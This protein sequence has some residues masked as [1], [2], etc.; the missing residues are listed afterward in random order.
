VVRFLH[1]GPRGGGGFGDFEAGSALVDSAL[2]L[3]G[4]AIKASIRSD[5]L[6]PASVTARSTE[7]G[8]LRRCYTPPKR[9]HDSAR[10][11][12]YSVKE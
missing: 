4:S 5:G 3:V 2:V 12:G 8:L 1:F 6:R 10:D 11:D 9:H 7:G